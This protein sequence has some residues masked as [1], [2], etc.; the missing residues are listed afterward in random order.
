MA[1]RPLLAAR[2]APAACRL[3]RPQGLVCY[4]CAA[5]PCDTRRGMSVTRGVWWR[6]VVGQQ[7]VVGPRGV[8]S[9]T[10]LGRRLRGAVGHFV[11]PSGLCF[12]LQ[13]FWGVCAICRD[14]GREG[15]VEVC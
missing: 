1:A 14:W 13:R 10:W 3:S 12:Q 6:A 15:F 4:G 8:G 5:P 11:G 9:S 7:V 2:Q